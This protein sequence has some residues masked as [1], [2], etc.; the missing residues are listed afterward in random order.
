MS[1]KGRLFIISGPSGTGKSTLI[2]TVLKKRPELRYSIS[3]TTRPPRGSE[4]NGEDYYFI[5]ENT[6]KERM[7]ADD[8]AE[9][10]EVHG[11][12]Y[13]T[14]AATI[15]ATLA[16]GEDLLLDIDVVGA[17]KLLVRFPEAISVFVAPP[18]LAELERRLT[19]RNTDS[20]AAVKRRLRNAE[21]EM[22]Q[23]DRYDHVV[24]NEDLIQAISKL[25]TILKNASVNGSS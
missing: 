12:F 11:H 10:A 18:T 17:R 1:K 16:K 13:G 22:A 15:E 25:E 23:A 5:S 20:P 2:E 6:F 9:W 19:A 7:E 8:F 24:V 4:K 3:Y 21:T 14:S